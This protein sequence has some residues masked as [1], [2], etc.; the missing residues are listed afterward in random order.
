MVA[1]NILNPGAG[2]DYQSDL[3]VA[4]TALANMLHTGKDVEYGITLAKKLLPFA[5]QP[6][7]PIDYFSRDRE[8]TLTRDGYTYALKWMRS[9]NFVTL[10]VGPANQGNII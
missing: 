2:E 5:S 9:A 3:I 7:N 6:E 1:G 4:A 8:E 10:R